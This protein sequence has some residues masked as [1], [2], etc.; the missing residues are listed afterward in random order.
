MRNKIIF[1]LPIFCDI[2]TTS[3]FIA[4]NKN[5]ED[6]NLMILYIIKVITFRWVKI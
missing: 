2:M 4:N 3:G 6:N 1:F 5:S